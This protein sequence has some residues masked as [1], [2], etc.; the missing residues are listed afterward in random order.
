MRLFLLFLS[1]VLAFLPMHA[2][3]DGEDSEAGVRQLQRQSFRIETPKAYVSGML[4]ANDTGSDING[5]MINEFGISAIDFTYSRKTGKVKLI[6]VVSF[7]NKWY[8]KRV[9]KKDIG[10]CLHVIFGTPFKSGHNYEVVH[11][12]DTVTIVNSKRNIRY[13]FSPLLNSTVEANTPVEN[14]IEE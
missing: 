6:N 11:T 3:P 14:D 7:L 10:F 9:L 13:T 8:I 4:I 2:M 5:S 1:S 12:S